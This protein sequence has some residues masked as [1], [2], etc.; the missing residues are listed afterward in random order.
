YD[1][2]TFDGKPHISIASL[3]GMWERTMT[4]SSVGKTFTVTGWKTGWLIAPSHLTH[5]MRMAHQWMLFCP[6]G[7]M[8]IATA[9]VINQAQENGYYDELRTM[10]QAKR[11]IVVEA[12]SDVGLDPY[13]SEGTYFVIADTRKL[14]CEDAQTACF[15][16][17]HEAGVAVIPPAPFYCEEHRPLSNFLARFAF[18]KEDSYLRQASAVL[19]KH[20][21]SA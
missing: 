2:L 18:C 17:L 1:Q 19:R 15:Y 8:Q 13:A 10:Y 3:P 9:D 11:D 21:E 12:L 7:P 6:T 5:N 14:D 16:L 4:T 20:F